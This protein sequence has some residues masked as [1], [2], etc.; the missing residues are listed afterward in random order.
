M[1][2]L[3]DDSVLRTLGH[4]LTT[5][6][7]K[8]GEFFDVLPCDSPAYEAHRAEIE[9][10]VS[11]AWQL[12]VLRDEFSEEILTTS[13]IVCAQP[14]E[15]ASVAGQYFKFAVQLVDIERKLRLRSEKPQKEPQSKSERRAQESEERGRA[16]I[17]RFRPFLTKLLATHLSVGEH[18]ATAKESPSDVA[19]CVEK[20][21]KEIH[22]LEEFCDEHRIPTL[23]P[24]LFDP[25]SFAEQLSRQD[26]LLENPNRRT[27]YRRL[28]SLFERH[29]RHLR[30][31]IA[32][33]E[34]QG[35]FADTLQL[36]E[37][38]A[39]EHRTP[40]PDF[41]RQKPFLCKTYI[42]ALCSLGSHQAFMDFCDDMGLH[43]YEISP[44]LLTAHIH[45]LTELEI[46]DH[47]LAL[48]Q[49][50]GP[51]PV[52]NPEMQ[53]TM[54]DVLESISWWLYGEGRHEEAVHFLERFAAKRITPDAQSSVSIAYQK[55]QEMLGRDS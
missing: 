11:R 44:T 47:A 14:P 34:E 43:P 7:V 36:I 26:Y 1:T 19:P 42:D 46:C 18:I 4:F 39:R 54:D 10:L 6:S 30:V 12:G 24:N 17:E 41:L 48:L 52:E 16:Y 21:T 2:T 20:Y 37:T 49:K 27:L 38:F 53:K 28:A 33:L 32:A 9:E 51:F 31:L 45:W 22:G 23:F 40:L 55:N 50:Y 25:S 13:G 5:M 3:T 15:R 29:E 8:P 35:E